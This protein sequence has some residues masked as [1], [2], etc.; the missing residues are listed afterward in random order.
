MKK[1]IILF[2]ILSALFL[3]LPVYAYVM[4]SASYRIQYDSVNSAGGTGS[5][6]DYQMNGSLGQLESGFS[7]STGYNLY[8]GYQKMDTTSSSISVSVSGNVS[9]LPEINGLT[10][11]S[12]TGSAIINVYTDNASGYTLEMSATGSP[13]LSSENDSFS[14][15]LPIINGTPDFVWPSISTASST[16]GYSVYSADANYIFKNNGSDCATGS[17]NSTSNC[18]YGLSLSPN[19]IAVSSGA[20][21]LG[22]VD[23]TVTLKAESGSARMQKNGT[24]GA[25]LVFTAYTN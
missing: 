16:F 15:F 3:A 7:S 4:E 19:G 20:T 6:T 24:Y 8:A 1:A 23:T 10:G 22:G 13:A 14:D 2:G 21:D 9:L 11:G 25:G 17:S 5:S 12:A 18:W